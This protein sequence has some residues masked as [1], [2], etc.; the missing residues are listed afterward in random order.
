MEKPVNSPSTSFGNHS[1]PSRFPLFSKQNK[2]CSGVK[3]LLLSGRG[4]KATR[5]AFSS[6]RTLEGRVVSAATPTG[7]T[8]YNTEVANTVVESR[9]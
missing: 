6:F 8:D 3:A 4:V 1:Q 9:K 2:V 7:K 5:E